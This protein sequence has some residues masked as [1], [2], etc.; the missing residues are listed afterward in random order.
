MALWALLFY[1]A[2]VLVQVRHQDRITCV[3]ISLGKRFVVRNGEGTRESWKSCQALMHV[4]PRGRKRMRAACVETPCAATQS[5]E[6]SV[7]PRGALQPK[8][9]I[10]E[11][12]VSQG[13]IC[14]G[15]PATLS[16]WLGEAYRRHSLRANVATDCRARQLEASV[17]CAL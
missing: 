8:S 17:N 2:C 7:R 13:P 9:A 5:Q 15:I 14:L 16:R 10:R 11:A 3:S 1:Q 12:R 4:W 6:G